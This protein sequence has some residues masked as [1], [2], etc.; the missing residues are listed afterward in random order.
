[1]SGQPFRLGSGGLLDRDR[2]VSFAFNGRTYAGYAGDTLA[3]ALLA[4]GVGLVGRSFKYHRPRGIVSSGVEEP[5]AW[6]QL[7]A[8]GREDPNLP[9]TV[10]ELYDGLVARSPNCWPSVGFDLGAVTGLLSRLFVAGF[11]NKTF[12][13]PAWLWPSYERAIRRLAGVGTAPAA[14]DPETYEDCHA[15]TDVLVVGAGPAGLC[16]ALAA[17]RAGARVIL[18]D[19]QPRWGGSLLSAHEE[20]D[21]TPGLDW[22]E[23]AV[24]ELNATARVR[25]LPRTTVF[26]CYDHN[27]VAALERRTDHL[28]PGARS[29]PRQR[30]W[31]I[32]PDQVVLATGAHER[33]LVFADNDRPGVMLASAARS[34]VNRYGVRPGTRAVVF[35]NNDSAWPAALDLAAAGVEVAALVDARGGLEGALVKRARAAG[36]EILDGSAVVA[37][38][39]GRRVRGVDVA[40]LEPGAAKTRRSIDCDLVCV[41]GGWSPAVHLFSQ[42]GGKLRYDEAKACFLPEGTARATWIAGAAK[43]AFTLA[44]CLAEGSET[45]AAAAAE[46]GF[47]KEGAPPPAT[48]AAAPETPIRPLWSVAAP[49]RR[50]KR[51]VDSFGD[52]TTEDIALAA[53]EGYVSVEHLKRYTTTGMGID[54]GKTGNI[55][56]LAFLAMETGAGI[57]EVG[58]TTYRPPYVPVGFGALARGHRGELY[59]PLRKTAIDPWHETNSA[60][61]EDFGLWRRPQYYA[62][63]GRTLQEAVSAE[64]RNVRGNVGLIDVSTL[65]KIHLHGPDVAEFLNRVYTNRWDS[66]KAGRCRYGVMLGEDGMVMD[67]GVTARLGELDYHMTTTTGG[68][69]GVFA[70]LDDLLQNDWPDLRVYMTSVT[71]QL[72][73]VAVAGPNARKLLGRVCTDIDLDPE[74][75]PFL[76]VREG[77]VAGIP[78]RVFTVSF[79]GELSYEVNVPSSYGLALWQALMAAGEELGVQPCGVEAMDWLR[80]EKGHFIVGRETDGTVT[81]VDLGLGWLV[82]MKKGDFLG[83]R[84]LAL[85]DLAR[86]DRLQLVG[87]LSE[88]GSGLLPEDGQIVAELRPAPPMPLDGHVTTS[89][90]APALGRP[91]A[92]A[93]LKRGRE[94][95]GETVTVWSEGRTQRATVTDPRFYDPDGERLNL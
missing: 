34:Y 89:C 68:A 42:T 58:T 25:L 10:V 16:A 76:S 84:S 90:I 67:D 82:N 86:P 1:V 63:H 41:S 15:K 64:A 11:Y 78:A 51:F 62:P 87:L 24:S 36:I 85:A 49:N 12:M 4:N 40:S 74:A 48:P 14:P 28:E 73:A 91:I 70:W 6:V 65:G 3:S 72:A 2:P 46:A 38:R 37:V 23:A 8:G 79:T 56:A 19:E 47:A 95:L 29:G 81:P 50:A 66:L 59:E 31:Q 53:R 77:S 94:R 71:T 61:F 17:A 69:P 45:G 60:V 27:F 7:G 20:I 5:N 26:G 43:G 93:L 22:V 75:F 92:L 52:V 18:A 44:G 35:T 21:G 9:A 55:N 33:P 80:A 13:R 83:R 30:L 39:G 32:R 57:A 54:Q 88:D